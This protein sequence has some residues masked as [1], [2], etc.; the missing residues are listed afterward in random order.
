MHNLYDSRQVMPIGH[1]EQSCRNTQS[2]IEMYPKFAEELVTVEKCFTMLVPSGGRPQQPRQNSFTSASAVRRHHPPDPV[3]KNKIVSPYIVAVDTVTSHESGNGYFTPTESPTSPDPHGSKFSRMP[4]PRYRQP[5][6]P[7]P[8]KRP[9]IALSRNGGRFKLIYLK[10]NS[11]L[12][13]NWG[14]LNSKWK[15]ENTK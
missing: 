13:L 14:Q 8:Q 12:L 6:P 1:I 7:P 9:G 5:P 15:Y 3:P 4:Q 2:H 11:I 10:L